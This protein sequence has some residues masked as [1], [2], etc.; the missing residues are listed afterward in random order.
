MA[1]FLPPRLLAKRTHAN[2]AIPRPELGPGLPFGRS[3]LD[4]PNATIHDVVRDILSADPG[5]HLELHCSPRVVDAMW[6][7]L[8]TP[9]RTL[10]REYGVDVIAEGDM[11][12]DQWRLQN[13]D[14]GEVYAERVYPVSLVRR[15]ERGG[16]G[17]LSV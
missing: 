1:R 15:S 3:P 13:A 7:P 12:R 10:T 5:T 2:R 8:R 9:M 4:E 14:G 17:V 6:G 11:R 16:P